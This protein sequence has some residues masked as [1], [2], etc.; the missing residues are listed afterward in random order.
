MID[1]DPLAALP[2]LAK[3]MDLHTITLKHEMQAAE[4]LLQQDNTRKGSKSDNTRKGSK[5]SGKLMLKN[6]VLDMKNV[7]FEK[8]KQ[9][10]GLMHRDAK[11]A[12]RVLDKLQFILN[13]KLLKN[14]I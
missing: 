12:A 3:V 2:G 11:Q 9:K 14:Q 6:N 8:A 5:S 7:G 13:C 1:P 10:V 4:K